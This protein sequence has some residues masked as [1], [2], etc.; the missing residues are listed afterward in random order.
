MP[1][2]SQIDAKMVNKRS[3]IAA[4]IP[5]IPA[6]NDH[7]D[8]SWNDT[9]IY[10][11]EIFVNIP[12]E[13][14]Y[15]RIDGVIKEFVAVGTAATGLNKDKFIVGIGG[16]TVFNTSSDIPNDYEVFEDGVISIAE[17]SKT[18]TNE[19]TFIPTIPEGTTI[20]IIY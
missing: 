6:S 14:I 10:S 4:E 2:L 15:I 9:D 11:G 5:T 20:T 18:D 7:T 8:G 13:K 17:H 16:Q 3:T 12:D 19:I 1:E